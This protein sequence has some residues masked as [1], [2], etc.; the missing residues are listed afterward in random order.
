MTIHTTTYALPLPRIGNLSYILFHG[1]ILVLWDRAGINPWPHP[2]VKWHKT[3]KKT[4][5]HRSGLESFRPHFVNKILFGGIAGAALLNTIPAK[6]TVST[7]ACMCLNFQIH[8]HAL[9]SQTMA[10]INV[11]RIS[12][13]HRF[14]FSVTRTVSFR[15][16]PSPAFRTPMTHVRRRGTALINFPVGEI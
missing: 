12:R 1:S 7:W 6:S 4:D 9:E 13:S 2:V 10:F 16:C 5:N 15:I 8:R 3:S 14:D 11:P